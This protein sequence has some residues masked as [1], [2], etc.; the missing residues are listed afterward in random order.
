M[1]IIQKVL[2]EL[3][4]MFMADARM[5]LSTVALVIIMAGLLKFAALSALVAGGLLL[6]GCLVIVI[7]A[8]VRD[9][10]KRVAARS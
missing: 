6:V 4:S 8:A 10:R 9:T 2:A 3:F 1:K 5:S 7:E